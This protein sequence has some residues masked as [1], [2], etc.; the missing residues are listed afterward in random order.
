MKPKIAV[1]LAG[2]G[3]KDGSEI[4]E[5]VLALT[6]LSM[7]GADFECFAPS[8][9]FDEVDH[10]TGE[11]T[12]RRR[13]VLQEAA[14]IARGKIES[15]DKLAAQSFDGLM[16]PGGFGVAKNLCTFA[17]EGANCQVDPQVERAVEDFIQDRKPIGA[18]CIA[19]A[20]VAKV[21]QKHGGVR[22]TVGAES[23]ASRA[24][25]S[26]GSKH[27]VSRADEIVIDL[28]HQ[29]V[30]TPAYMYDDASLSDI[31]TGISKLARQLVIWSSSK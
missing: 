11:L 23:E 25:A 4:R 6:A 24:I 28:D 9:D 8:K 20:L 19:P 14:R 27:M 1:V 10:L 13:N 15:I 12:G 5:A 3:F 18:I 2:C 26:M 7:N 17:T 30:T 29:V 16:L 31:F 22:L 21:F